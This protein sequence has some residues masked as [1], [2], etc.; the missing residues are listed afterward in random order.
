APTW[1]PAM[2]AP[3]TDE[4]RRLLLND[5]AIPLELAQDVEDICRRRGYGRGAARKHI[6]QEIKLQYYFGGQGGSYLAT[7]EGPL[8]VAAGDMS[9]PAFGRALEALSNDERRNVTL[10]SPARWNDSTSSINGV[11]Q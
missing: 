6:E 4:P 7:A 1:E 5:L 11:G 9:S 3:S 8:V 10:Y 2:P